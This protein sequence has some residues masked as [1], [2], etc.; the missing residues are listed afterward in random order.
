MTP[1]ETK[2]AKDT[3][4]WVRVLVRLRNKYKDFYRYESKMADALNFASE[5]CGYSGY[6]IPA[7]NTM[8]L[9]RLYKRIKRENKK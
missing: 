9:E 6:K 7:M 1:E 3:A 4:K 8:K 2:L 5:I